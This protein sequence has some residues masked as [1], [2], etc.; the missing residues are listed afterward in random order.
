MMPDQPKRGSA[1]R[2]IRLSWGLLTVSERWWGVL[3]AFA[4]VLASLL[5]T[6][7]LIGVMPLVSLIVQPEVL[8]TN[9]AIRS[10][11][12]LVG[13]PEFDVFVKMA[14]ASAIGLITA[15]IGMNLLMMYV[16]KRFR[17]A[18]QNRLAGQ[19][20]TRCVEAPYDWHLR[21]S[22][23]TLAHHVFN[24][25]LAWSSGG[26]QGMFAVVSHVSLLILVSI[27]VLSA[28]ALSGVI[29]MLIIGIL[30]AAVMLLLRPKIRYLSEFRRVASAQAFSFASEFLGGIK[31]VKLSGREP[32]FVRVFGVAFDAYGNA[33][34]SL[35][36]LQATPPLAMLFLG[37][38]G[39]IVIVLILWGSGRSGGEVAAEMALVLLVTARIIP[40]INRLVGVIG[41]LWNVIPNI[42]GIYSLRRQLSP[43]METGRDIPGLE[44]LSDWRRIELVGLGY[45]YSSER[46]IAIHGVNATIERG[47]SY[48]IVGPTGAGKTTFV[49]LL[50]GLLHPSEGEITVD[51]T[52]LTAEN[53][54]AWQRG[55]GYVPQNPLIADDTLLANVAFGVT[56]NEVDEA[57]VLHCL[58]IANLGDVLESMTLR[59]NLGEHGNLLSGGQCQR[60]AIARALYDEPDLLVLDEATSSLDT[61]SERAVQ[62][63][64]ENLHGIVT[65]ITVAHRLSTIEKCDE[66]FLI[67][68]G[69]LAARGN[70][71]KLLRTSPLFARMAASGNNNGQALD[72]EEN[73]REMGV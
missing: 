43:L 47:K 4:N 19:L 27:V 58:E 31:D 21:Q 54:R 41:T 60:V 61:L 57:R 7:S 24:D 45:R 63:A 66:I 71:D 35:K 69:Q 50:L 40:V 18:C 37:Q 32:F 20:M 12:E 1:W 62:T 42:E 73:T 59:G 13:A 56:A 38:T 10:L 49:D 67:E 16:I 2:A 44:N 25:I 22:S 17:V 70:Y 11:H 68:N 14:A 36:L 72:E 15:S 8:D 28:A 9:Q 29:G 53:A 6:I 26:I 23:T 39:I 55:I 33:M 52:P 5:D 65:T 51:E 30:A 3:I 48:G 46:A 64:L 34:G